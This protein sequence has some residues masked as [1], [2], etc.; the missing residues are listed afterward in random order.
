MLTVDRDGVKKGEGE[1]SIGEGTNV[2]ILASHGNSNSSLTLSSLNTQVLNT[3]FKR[4]ES[5]K[6]QAKIPNP[7]PK[8]AFALT[9]PCR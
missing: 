7:K 3:M 1:K 9:F 5:R 6:L 8:N 4:F 2:Y